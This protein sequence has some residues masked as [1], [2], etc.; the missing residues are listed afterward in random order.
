MVIPAVDV[1][2]GMWIP[3]TIAW[4]QDEVFTLPGSPHDER[5][6]QI[7][8]VF[9]RD[10]VPLFTGGAGLIEEHGRAGR[11]PPGFSAFEFDLPASHQILGR[12]L[13]NKPLMLEPSLE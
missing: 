7:C 13:D 8:T 12:T 4:H 9:N 10:R 3:V 11:L 2:A 1:V 5:K 6:A